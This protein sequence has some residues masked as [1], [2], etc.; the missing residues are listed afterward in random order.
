MIQ[1]QPPQNAQKDLRFL[2]MTVQNIGSATT[3]LTIFEFFRT[4]PKW[5]RFLTKFHF[6]KRA[7]ETRAVLNLYSGPQ[8]PHKLEVGSEWVG[9]M[10]QDEEFE[11][12]LKT[13]RLYCAMHHSFALRP[14]AKKIIRG[15][16]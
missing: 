7:N 16:V 15:P 8:L 1:L 5:Q 12:W 9:L 6:K 2:I 3:S 4:I 11:D 13:E 10:V 14:V